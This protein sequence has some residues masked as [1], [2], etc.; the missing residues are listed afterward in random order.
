MSE[1]T[2][3]PLQRYPEAAD[4]TPAGVIEHWCEHAGCSRCGAFG[5]RPPPLMA[6]CRYRRSM[7]DFG[8]QMCDAAELKAT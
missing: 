3:G 1:Q 6:G 5:F 2:A 7:P 4:R 8:L